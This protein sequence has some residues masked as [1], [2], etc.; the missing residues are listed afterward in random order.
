MKLFKIV[1]YRLCFETRFSHKELNILLKHHYGR[2]MSPS[3]SSESLLETGLYLHKEDIIFIII[4][5]G[6][7]K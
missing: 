2:K 4:P 6:Q 7:F 3:E 1:S 5:R